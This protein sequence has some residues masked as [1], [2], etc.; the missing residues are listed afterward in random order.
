MAKNYNTEPEENDDVFID[1]EYNPLNEPINEKPYTRP[2][3]S[4]NQNDLKGDIPEPDFTPPPLGSQVDPFEEEVINTKK[5]QQSSKPQPKPRPEPVNPELIGA[6]KKEFNKSA[7]TLAEM[8][9]SGYEMLCKIANNYVKISDTKIQKLVREDKISLSMQ[10]PYDGYNTMSVDEL[11]KE[12]NEQQEDLLTVDPEWK[13]ETMPVLITVLEK[14]GLGATP[15]NH[16]A[17]LVAKSVGTNVMILTSALT[18]KKQLI[19]SLTMLYDQNKAQN[20]QNRPTQNQNTTYTQSN[21][22]ENTEQTSTP[23]SQAEP[24]EF[25]PLGEDINFTD[26]EDTLS[27]NYQVNQMTN[28]DGTNDNSTKRRGR[29]KKDK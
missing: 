12:F 18:Q 15:E 21:F 7:K 10:V 6:S 14:R 27:V 13:E 2:N 9:M 17:F 11:F 24:E 4:I 20:I 3:V 28:P 22:T 26:V 5:S 16:L 1:S 23:V 19:N 25:D 29:P 8:G